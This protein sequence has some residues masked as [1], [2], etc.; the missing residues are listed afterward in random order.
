MSGKIFEEVQAALLNSECSP[1]YAVERAL[2]AV[3]Q[4][5]P[6]ACLHKPDCK[7]DAALRKAGVR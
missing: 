2:V 4:F 3:A 7:L 6:D 5:A 1:E